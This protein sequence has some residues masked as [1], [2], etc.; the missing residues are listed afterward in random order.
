MLPYLKNSTI[1]TKP[2]LFQLR[3]IGFVDERDRH[4]WITRSQCPA[5]KKPKE[6]ECMTLQFQNMAGVFIV[7][8]SG[9]IISFILLVVE[10]KFKWVVDLILEAGVS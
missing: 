8:I 3:E 6:L 7:L 1:I 4:W 9:V 5:K 10:V 2:C